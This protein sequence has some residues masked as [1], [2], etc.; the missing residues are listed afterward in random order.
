MWQHREGDQRGGGLAIL[1][2][3][4]VHFKPMQLV[5]FNNSQMEI[6]AITILVNKS[7]NLN[8]LNVYN[9]NKIIS[10]DEY[11]CYFKQLGE[12]GIIVGD[13]NCHHNL[14][15][16][17]N[18]QDAAGHKLA[19]ALLLNPSITLLT[20]PTT[21][22]YFNVYTNHS[23]TIDLCFVS[24]HLFTMAHVTAEDDLGS[25]HYPMLTC[26][27]VKPDTTRF[28][29]RPRWRFTEEGWEQWPGNLPDIAEDGFFPEMSK[30][31]LEEHSQHLVDLMNEANSASFKRTTGVVSTKFN[32]PWWSE[33][34]EK[35][36]E[37]KHIAKAKLDRHPTPDHLKDYNKCS[38]LAKREINISKKNSWKTF[39]NSF[40]SNTTTKTLWNN[41]GKLKGNIARRTNPIVTPTE[42]IIDSEGKAN[43]I[44]QHYNLVFNAPPPPTDPTPL[45]LPLTLALCDDSLKQHNEP[46]KEFE[47][48]KALSSLKDTS[49]GHDDVSNAHLK[50]LPPEYQKYLLNIF[51]NSLSTSHVPKSWK[52]AIVIPIHKPN[53]DPT[54]VESYRPIS[55]LSCIAKLME[56][57]VFNRLYYHIEA[58]ASLSNTQTG[59]R[60]R[61]STMEQLA[62][63]EKSVRTTLAY[64][65]VGI[66]V[67]FDLAGAFDTVW[68]TGLL[69]KLAETGI[70]GGLLRWV[71]AYLENRMFSVTMEGEESEV[72]SAASGVPQ[73]AILSPLLF[74]IMIKDLPK[75]PNVTTYEFA[76]DITMYSTGRDLNNVVQTIQNA[77]NLF[78]SFTIKWNLKIS[79]IKTECV[80]FTNRR[81]IT[82][83]VI[84]INNNR[85][86]FVKK[87][88]FLGM[89][90]DGPKLT[91]KAHIE[92]LKI[93]SS[94]KLNPLKAVSHCHW[95]ADRLILS[96]MYTALIRSRLDY[97]AVLYDTAPESSLKKLNVIQNTALRIM[98]G[99]RQTS[100]IVS[101]EA[102][103]H[104]PPLV[105]HR[106]SLMCKY[107]YRI[108]TLPTDS[109]IVRELFLEEIN[110]PSPWS[111]TAAT[112]P[113][114]QRAQELFMDLEVLPSP[115]IFSPLISPIPPYV[116]LNEIFRPQFIEGVTVA[117]MV[118]GE[119]KD[120]FKVIVNKC[121]QN[122]LQIFTDGSRVEDPLPSVSCAVVIPSRG[123]TERWKLPEAV[124]VMGAE[125]LAIK[126]AIVY[127]N[128][129][130]QIINKAVIFSDSLSSILLL[131]NRN[132]TSYLHL[133]Y[134]IHRLIYKM[135][136]EVE[137][138][139]QFVP[140]HQKIDGNERA[141]AAAS[142][143]HRCTTVT[144]CQL[145]REELVRCALQRVALRWTEHWR[146]EVRRTGKGEHLLKIKDKLEYWPWSNHQ[147]RSLETAMAR[148][149]L[150]HVGLMKHMNRFQ[151][152]DTPQCDC[153]Q[154]EE[155]VE[156]FLLGCRIHGVHRSKL[157][158]EIALIK[159]DFNLKNLLGGGLYPEH[160]QL[161]I[162]EHVGRFLANTSK[163]SKL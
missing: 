72:H 141:D 123:V 144:R 63:F 6:Q 133:V 29:T 108:A 62:R 117:Q 21:P 140:G 42:T 104:I 91:W 129:N 160:I 39:C 150:G 161:Q 86:E 16:E 154:A 25:D 90:I 38:A 121:F 131:Q 17:K 130:K 124:T 159:V 106:K 111:L 45:L 61:Y 26:L 85:I 112:K 145:S 153:G 100:P 1:V 73:G 20:T 162:V 97:G 148:L 95:G 40:S 35:L 79:S 43:A 2:R 31:Q 58:S 48:H 55:L 149:R 66:A 83:P 146:E 152:R 101:L 46:F 107:Y 44:A 8:I 139:L 87:H 5:P 76:D 118:A 47:L 105:I 127:V 11:D 142:E 96:K 15:D 125:L 13:F 122:F 18:R 134:E 19:D 65:D 64:G 53:K 88:R 4:D 114:L 10:T 51:N 158:S 70:S 116:D 93:T 41:V 77:I 151:M 71:R 126:N 94:R 82:P 147:A 24:S 119:A 92:N 132:P 67:F 80:L 3:N 68:H 156:H 137:I 157:Q 102:E 22:T 99:A 84:N 9:P 30:V 57:L 115:G 52:K 138:V 49:P 54:R 109:P 37:D 69:Y 75:P 32:K 136:R 12:R 78:H 34:C 56:R 113:F 28:K 128:N 74:N 103:C 60:R 81:S 7:L 33:K 14:W 59:Y 98:S 135:N 27:A 89:T 163:L 50:H 143:A 23:S 120:K 155:T 110:G 36:I